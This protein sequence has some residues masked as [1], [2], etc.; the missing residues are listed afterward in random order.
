M[1]NRSVGPVQA[2]CNGA[3]V[4]LSPLATANRAREL[5]IRRGAPQILYG[6]SMILSENRYPFFGIML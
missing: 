4:S 1:F 3:A 5:T 2:P 6:W